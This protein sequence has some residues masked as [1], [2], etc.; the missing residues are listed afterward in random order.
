MYFNIDKCGKYQI[1]PYNMICG[2]HLSNYVPLNI[3]IARLWHAPAEEGWE[4]MY[5]TACRCLLTNAMT[6][7]FSCKPQIIRKWRI[8][9]PSCDWFTRH[10]N[11]CNRIG[12]L[13]SP[14]ASTISSNNNNYD[15]SSLNWKK[16]NIYCYSIYTHISVHC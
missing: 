4:N 10:P 8:K 9:H 3:Y 15:S 7:W 5:A 16:K 14:A 12:Y 1:W 6:Q 13:H 11:T 2:W